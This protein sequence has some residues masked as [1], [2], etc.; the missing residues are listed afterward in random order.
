MAQDNG[1]V[2]FFCWRRPIEL[3]GDEKDENLGLKAHESWEW[4]SNDLSIKSLWEFLSTRDIDFLLYPCKNALKILMAYN[5]I[6]SSLFLFSSSRRCLGV[7]CCSEHIKYTAARRETEKNRLISLRYVINYDSLNPIRGREKYINCTPMCVLY[8][9]KVAVAS[10]LIQKQRFNVILST[11]DIHLAQNSLG[12]CYGFVAV[13]FL[14]S[15]E[16]GKVCFLCIQR[17]SI[18]NFPWFLPFMGVLLCWAT[19]K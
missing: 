18:Y 17:N 5:S 16:M 12:T 1:F 13:K 4:L 11:R 6:S 15:I 19:E 10:Q 7:V 8:M 2:S 9:L 14:I 3:S